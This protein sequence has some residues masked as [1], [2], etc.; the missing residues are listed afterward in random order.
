[1]TS[2]IRSFFESYAALLTALA[3][4][5]VLENFITLEW[6]LPY[7][8]NPEDG[9]AYAAFGMPL[10]YITYSGVSSAEFLLMPHVYVFNIAALLLVL[11]PLVRYLSRQPQKRAP[12]SL[13]W[14]GAASTVV[15]CLVAGTFA[16]ELG[17]GMLRT[18]DSIGIE[19]YGRYQELR[20]VGFASGATAERCT[21]SRFWFPGGWHGH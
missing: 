3:L 21:P 11:A 16:L 5:L 17:I 7:C 1:M 4:V 6:S 15:V 20:P 8:S 10:P 19:G 2:S 9:P 13:V 18:V 12:Q 14:F